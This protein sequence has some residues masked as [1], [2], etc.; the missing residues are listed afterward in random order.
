ML[1]VATSPPLLSNING[2]NPSMS[3]SSIVM[4][5]HNIDSSTSVPLSDNNTN[6]KT[7]VKKR[8]HGYHNTQV[9]T[10]P[11]YD[12]VEPLF[13]GSPLHL[14]G[15]VTVSNRLSSNLPNRLQKKQQEQMR[16]VF[17]QFWG[18]LKNKKTILPSSSSSNS[19]SYNS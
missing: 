4:S 18:E 14:V 3:M 10:Y 11:I 12:E 6:K 1:Y 7:R 8:K 13:V 16:F 2:P 9:S 15:R 5:V 19:S 17:F